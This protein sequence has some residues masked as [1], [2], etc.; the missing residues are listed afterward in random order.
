MKHLTWLALCGLALAGCDGSGG[1]TPAP[2]GG[3]SV[4]EN[5]F[6]GGS[7]AP[8]GEADR[9]I[10]L[11]TFTDPLQHAQQAED[12]RRKITEKLG[13][14]DVF[15]HT[16]KGRSVLLWGRYVTDDQAQSNLRKAKTYRAADGTAVF[17]QAFIAPLPG[18]TDTGPAEWNLKNA[19]GAYT[20][21]VA[22]F[23]D[24]PEHKYVGRKK[25]DAVDLVKK[26][27]DAG[28]EAYFYHQPGMSN[29]TIGSF[30][31]NAVRREGDNVTVLDPRVT[32]L[33]QEFP[34]LLVNGNTITDIKRDPKTQQVTKITQK[35]YL[36]A[37]PREGSNAATPDR[38]GQPQPR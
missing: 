25:G 27:R 7:A 6:G 18:G 24:D 2:S 22:V 30:P 16:E 20:L 21:L 15:V 37:I 23:K 13:W 34:E 29:V 1:A 11:A 33:Q 32:Q 26:L 3:G 31:A 17:A 35:T 36:V 38:P 12:Y 19:T 10:I 8:A 14:K 5:L 9:T 28:R 4:L